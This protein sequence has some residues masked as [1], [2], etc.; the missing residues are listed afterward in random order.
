MELTFEMKNKK[1]DIRVDLGR[2]QG[3]R[4]GGGRERRV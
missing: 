3:A 2:N 4:E 1:K